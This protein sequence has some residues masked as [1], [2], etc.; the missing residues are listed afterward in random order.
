MSSSPLTRSLVAASVAVCIL[1]ATAF[2]TTAAGPAAALERP[3]QAFLRLVDEAAARGEITSEAALLQK[4]TYV[5]EP[6]A[7][8]ARFRV[9]NPTPL[10]CATDLLRQFNETRATLSPE[11]VALVEGWLAQS[12]PD[13]AAQ[14]SPDAPS[15]LAAYVSPAGHFELTYSTTGSNAV[16]A[17]DVS[18]AN[19]VPDFIEWCASYCD[20]AWQREVVELG[21]T[22]PFVLDFYDIG[23]QAMS[24]YG[25]TTTTGDGTRIVLHRS[26]LGFPPNDDPDGDQKGA[27]KVT[28][29]H[30]FKHA[31]QYQGSFWS[32]GGWVELDATWVEDAVFDQTNDYYNFISS[33]SPIVAPAASLDQGGTGSYEDC[34]WQ[35]YMSQTYGDQIIFDLWERRKFNT[36]ET[37]KTSYDST[38][39]AYGST[40]PLGYE[41]FMVWCYLTGTRATT[42]IPGFGEA[43]AYPTSPITQVTTTLPWSY[44]GGVDHLAANFFRAV[45]GGSFV[46]APRLVFTGTAGSLLNVHAVYH[47][48]DG[49]ESRQEIALDGANS[50]N[51]LLPRPWS[52]LSAIGIVVVNGK[53]SGATI[54]YTVSLSED[55]LTGVRGGALDDASTPRFALEQNVPNPASP[56]TS[57]RFRLP[58]QEIVRLAVYDAAG[59][60][61]ATLVDGTALGPGEHEAR[62]DG[63]SDGG[64]AAA[65][66]VYAYRLVAG[67]FSETRKLL[68]VR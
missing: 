40:M 57:V 30:E 29:A 67:R 11:A 18:P 13:A 54:P 17:A 10:K 47:H 56:A 6:D 22:A 36:G 9:A 15:T 4:L 20:S 37:M 50:A 28:C 48:T 39:A 66:G 14:K 61:V 2:A 59:R 64:R 19:G 25:F 16:P 68:L 5:F 34:S 32:E 7:V 62:W 24:A 65:P 38:L 60:L 12:D 52:D 45:N 31:T 3:D 43:A 41:E 55:A 1:A 27:A 63:Q 23:F 42:D 21:F 58:Q 49:G 51:V 53:K 26:F 8:D 46:G 44:S 35:E 33:G